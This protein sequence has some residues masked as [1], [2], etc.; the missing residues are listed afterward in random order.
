[1]LRTAPKPEGPWAVDIPAYNANPPSGKLIY[2]GVA[3]P[4]LDTSG[5]T[6]T[7][8]YTKESNIIEVVKIS[9]H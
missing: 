6:L 4:Y 2:A 7:V 3:H 9:F 8:S 1:M 5:K